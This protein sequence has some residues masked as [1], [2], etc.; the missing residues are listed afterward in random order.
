M[1]HFSEQELK[2]FRK[3]T[4]PAKI[5]DFLENIPV[6]FEQGRQTCMSPRMVL[7]NR[8]A[9]CMEAAV[10]AA[11]ALRVIGHPPLVLDLHAAKPDFDHAI[12][13]FKI[14]G[15]WGAISK[16][17]H[18]VLRYRDPVYKSIRELVMSYF[19]EYFLDSG[20][21]T[22]RSFSK[23]VDLSRFDHKNWKTSEEDIWYIDEYLGK[24]KHYPIRPKKI[25]LRRADPLEIKATK[26]TRYKK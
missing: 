24:I 23:P 1:S 15:L 11:A 16:S 5:Q 2:V 21:K 3:L 13:P 9:H 26:N 20:R 17:N 6:N 22:L 4:T 8:R 14:K 7:K 10:L 12:A 18:P 25:K 19:H